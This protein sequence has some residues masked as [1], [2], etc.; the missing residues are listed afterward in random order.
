MAEGAIVPQSETIKP[1]F[2]PD[3][4][5]RAWVF[6]EYVR[7]TAD[8]AFDDITIRTLEKIAEWIKTGAVP[9]EKATTRHLKAVEPSKA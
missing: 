3:Q 8:P 2:E 9:A 5:Q 7:V 4:S 6:Q 1:L